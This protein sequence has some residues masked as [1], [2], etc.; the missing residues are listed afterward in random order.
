MDDVFMG[1]GKGNIQHDACPFWGASVPLCEHGH[2]KDV[3]ALNAQ[4]WQG[5]PLVHN[6]PLILLL[7]TSS[8]GMSAT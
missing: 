6:C 7:T 1:V 5:L 3:N 4:E 2:V 8:S